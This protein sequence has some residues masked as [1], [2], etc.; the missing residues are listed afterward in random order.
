MTTN[1]ELLGEKKEILL[2]GYFYHTIGNTENLRIRDRKQ[3]TQSH[4][5][6]KTLTIL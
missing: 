6:D 5:E 1:K 4:N 2:S 3:D